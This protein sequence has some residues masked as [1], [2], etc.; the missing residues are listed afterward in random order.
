MAD[1]ERITPPVLSTAE[2]QALLGKE[3]V[4]SPSNAPAVIAPRHY[5][6]ER[7]VS[8]RYCTRCTALIPD[9]RVARGSC[10]CSSECRRIDKMERRRTKAEK[11]CRLCGRASRKAKSGQSATRAL[12]EAPRPCAPVHTS[13]H[14]TCGVIFG[15]DISG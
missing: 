9:G 2:Y 6:N 3:R 1:D 15:N 10:F 7:S 13:F 4:T 14:P 8:T 5:R 11:C 12:I